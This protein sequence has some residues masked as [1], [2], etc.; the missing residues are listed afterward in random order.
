MAGSTTFTTKDETIDVFNALEEH[1]GIGTQTRPVCFRERKSKG[2]KECGATTTYAVYPC[3]ASKGKN[4]AGKETL[5]I[6]LEDYRG[7]ALI[8]NLVPASHSYLDG[9]LYIP[10][11][12]CLR[13]GAAEDG[14][15]DGLHGRGKH[16]RTDELSPEEKSSFLQ[17]PHSFST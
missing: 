3:K 10:M 1:Y 7:V 8:L 2:G 5:N 6:H 13:C 12:I 15:R 4:M 11:T 17:I 9:K 16:P 14:Y